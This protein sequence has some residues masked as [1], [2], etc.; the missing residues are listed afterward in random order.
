ARYAPLFILPA[1]ALLAVFQIYPMAS[2][3]LISLTEWNGFDSRIPTGFANFKA[4][5]GDAN[6]RVALLN[7]CYYVAGCVPGTLVFSVI[8][9]SFLNQK[10][11]FTSFFRALYYLPAI[12]SGVSIALIWRWIFNT[13]YGLLNVMLYS[14]GMKEMIPWLTS[15]R[16][17][18]PA[19]IIMSVWKSLG[20][21]II[22]ILAGLQS[23]PA[24]FHE[25]AVIDGAN[26]RQRFFKIT[27]PMLSP[28]L[29]MVIILAIIGSFQVFDTVLTLTKGGPGNAT[30]VIVYYI[31]RTAF[32]NFNMGYA[33]AMA[34]ILFAIILAVTI[35]QWLVKRKWVYS[36]DE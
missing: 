25:A 16:Y 1:F 17:A 29:F 20:S 34:F 28:T 11:R 10:I 13:N 21:N 2:G 22:L 9:A 31:Y 14:L 15:T 3:F 23:V 19:V 24:V 26:R 32:E 36:E 30:L 5:F 27:L 12:T 6:F 4:A 33:S 8:I 35:V 18:M 7:T